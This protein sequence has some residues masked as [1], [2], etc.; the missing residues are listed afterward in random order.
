MID[1]GGS[2][3]QSGIAGGVNSVDFCKVYEKTPSL[4]SGEDATSFI[5]KRLIL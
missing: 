5:L 1:V 4:A 2:M 3:L